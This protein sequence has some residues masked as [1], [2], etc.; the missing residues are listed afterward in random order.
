MKKYAFIFAALLA[1]FAGKAHADDFRGYNIWQSS[2]VTTYQNGVKVTTGNL[3]IDRIEI[4]SAGSSNAEFHFYDAYLSSNTAEA[5]FEGYQASSARPIQLHVETSTGLYVSN[6][7][8]TPAKVQ[9]F[10][11]FRTRE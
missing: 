10:Y 1:A 4:I 3:V 9:I 6:I 2:I 8:D 11:K 5:R 7:G